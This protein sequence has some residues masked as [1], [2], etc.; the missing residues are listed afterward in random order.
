MTQ[1]GFFTRVAGGFAGRLRTLSL[2]AELTFVPG[3]AGG[4]EHAPD[5]RIHLGDS[6]AGPEVGAGW[7]RIGE[8]AGEYVSVALDDPLLAQPI[9]ATLFQAGRGKNEWQLVWNRPAKRLGDRE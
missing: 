6:N 1:I 2:D 3:E 7:K 8:R 9:R 5:Y 4:A